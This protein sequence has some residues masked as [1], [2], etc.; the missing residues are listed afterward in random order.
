M[1]KIK[2]IC[3]GKI[4]NK[5]LITEIND[6]KKRLSR[7][8]IIE[9]KE[10]KEKN[11]NILKKKECELIS[12]HLTKSNYNILLIENGLEFSTQKFYE[13]FGRENREINF[14]ITGAFGPNDEL[15]NK[16]DFHLSLSKLTFTH[17]QA[18][19]ILIE[20]IYRMQCIEKNIPY[21]K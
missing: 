10:I 19:Y 8:E 18:Q 12:K 1:N 2:I 11:I 20:Q 7:F 4:K 5:S 16:V 13:K 9:L 21:T 6:L 17:E 14:I 15:K 3:I